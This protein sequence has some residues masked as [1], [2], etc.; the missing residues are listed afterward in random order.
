MFFVSCALLQCPS[1]D[2]W[3]DKTKSKVGLG[4]ASRM[5]GRWVT[6]GDWSGLRVL[7]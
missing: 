2:G 3:K 1:E 4:W 6:P 5:G 7:H